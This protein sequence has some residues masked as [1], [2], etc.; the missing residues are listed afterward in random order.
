MAAANPRTVVV[1][2]MAGA[3]VTGGLAARRAGDPDGLVS[4]AWRAAR[5]LADVL[6]GTA[7]PG[8]RLPFVVPRDEADLPPF[9]KTRPR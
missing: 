2:M 9:D 1:V 6:L 5:A 3:A 4:R 8:G 7:E